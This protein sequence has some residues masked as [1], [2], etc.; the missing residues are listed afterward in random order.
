MAANG[1]LAVMACVAPA[2][3]PIRVAPRPESSGISDVE[4]RP[5]FGCG[6]LPDST[7]HTDIID[8]NCSDNDRSDSTPNN[9]M[10]TVGGD[11]GPRAGHSYED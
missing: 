2:W 8:N 9:S 5:R 6:L 3:S 4:D 10:I 11:V 7:G 1:L